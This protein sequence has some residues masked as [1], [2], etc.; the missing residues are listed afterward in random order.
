MLM[1]CCKKKIASADRNHKR[2][3]AMQKLEDER[4]KKAKAKSKTPQTELS[5]ENISDDDYENRFTVEVVE[6]GKNKILYIAAACA[7]I[8]AVGGGYF[9][10]SV[11]QATQAKEVDFSVASS[12]APSAA[13]TDTQANVAVAEEVE[14]VTEAN[15]YSS[16]QSQMASIDELKHQLVALN[17]AVGMSSTMSGLL[18]NVDDPLQQI[19]G[20]HYACLLYTSPSPRDS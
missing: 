17:D 9:A 6:E 1:Q 14:T 12:D 10:Y 7:L 8:A 15:P 13:D 16:W 20:G 11:N 3:A 5:P 19:V 2:I 18:A 4:R